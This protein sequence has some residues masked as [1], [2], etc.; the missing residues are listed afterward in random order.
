VNER[1]RAREVRLID[2]NGGQMGI[3]AA[4]E[5]LRIAQERDLDLIEVAPRAQPPVCRIMDYGKHKYQQAKRRRDAHKKHKGSEVRVLVV[6]NPQIAQ[7]DL[8][9]K[10][11]KLRE[12]LHEGDKVRINLRLRGRQM[13]R[14]QLG[15]DVL[16][17]VAR[18]LGDVAQVEAPPRREGR[19]ISMLVAPKPGLKA[20]VPK[21]AKAAPDGEKQVEK[22]QAERPP[23]AERPREAEDAEDSGE[24]G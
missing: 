19:V 3:V 20:A 17:R 15:I 6:R 18:E 21:K 9:I 16:N 8:E 13:S 14:P 12:M 1:I 22:E 5:A 10:L 2:E 11:R 23:V 4:R 24:A 7:H